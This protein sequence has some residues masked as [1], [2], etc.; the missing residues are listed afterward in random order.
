MNTNQSMSELIAQFEAELMA[1]HKTT[2]PEQ[3]ATEQQRRKAQ[4]EHEAKHTAT[5]TDE[6]R[7]N[8]DEY[9]KEN[10]E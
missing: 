1:R 9:P 3:L 8:L 7:K 4:R 10:N 2:T 5:E 6:D